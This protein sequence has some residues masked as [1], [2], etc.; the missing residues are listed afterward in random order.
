MISTC[1]VREPKPPK[2][3]TGDMTST[4]RWSPSRNRRSRRCPHTRSARASFAVCS[5]DPHLGAEMSKLN[6]TDWIWRDGEFV[7]WDDANLHVLSHSM[8]YGSAAFEGIRCYDT[9]R[10]PAIFRLDAHL[11][12]LAHVLPH[13]SHGR[14]LLRR[15]PAQRLLRARRQERTRRLLH[16]PDGPPRLRRVEHGAVREPRPRLPAV[17]ALGRVPRRRRPGER[18]RCLRLVVA[19][20]RA[21][22]DARHRE[23]RRQ[24]P[25]QSAHQDGSAR[26]R[27][28]GSDR[29]RQRTA[30]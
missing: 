17:L 11:Q 7:R 22:H 10:G 27:L 15:R 20:R 13:L 12:R 1:R 5:T 21:E 9:P 8:Q 4:R 23:D 16:P 25:E 28:P 6:A 29:A 3:K 30:C 24:L 14:R 2:P 19:T 18:R 26:E